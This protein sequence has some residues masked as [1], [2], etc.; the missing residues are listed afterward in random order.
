MSIRRTAILCLL[1]LFACRRAPAGPDPN[2]EQASKLYQQLYASELDDAYGDPQMD[3]VV[4]FLKK[5]DSSSADAD[6]AR[7][8][9]GAIQ[10]GREVL[11][12]QRADREKMA[13]AAAA[14]AATAVVNIDPSAVIAASAPVDAGPPQDPYGPGAQ[15]SD[16][17]SASGGCL[18]DNEPFTEQ[19]TGV[20]GLVYRVV[21]TANCAG[22]LPGFVGQAVLVVNGKIYRRIADPN[23][24]KPPAPPVRDAGPPAQARATPPAA[25]QADGG[26]PEYQIVLPGQPQPGATPPAEQTQR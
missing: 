22:K 8:M 9:L 6:A 19:G 10:N 7:A 4:A 26:E 12:K 16:I 17:N 24:P 13:A 23:P 21:P 18:T 15:V 5:V 1:A 25:G 3:R 2:Y 11:A 14:S 20:A